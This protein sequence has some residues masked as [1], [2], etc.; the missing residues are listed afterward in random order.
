MTKNRYSCCLCLPCFVMVFWCI[1][2]HF[3]GIFCCYVCDNA[4]L[5]VWCWLKSLVFCYGFRNV[6][7]Y[8]AKQWQIFYLHME[9]SGLI[10]MSFFFLIRDFWDSFSYI[11]GP[12]LYCYKIVWFVKG[13]VFLDKHRKEHSR[14]IVEQ[15]RKSFQ[16]V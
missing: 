4:T 9:G 10:S 6:S 12:L 16:Q 3:V 2:I 5:F 7:A 1:F 13:I 14:Y 15:S 8:V 11:L